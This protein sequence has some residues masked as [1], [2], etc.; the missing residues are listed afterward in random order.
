MLFSENIAVSTD[1]G[2]PRV[3]FRDKMGRKLTPKQG[4][5]KV[6]NRLYNYL[7][8][9]ELFIVRLAGFIPIYFLRWIIYRLA[10]VKIGSGSHIHM[11]AQFFFPAGV[12]IG[13]GSIIGQNAFLDGRESL[14]IGNYVDIASDVMIYNS[15]H[16]INSEDFSAH[17]EPVEIGDYTFIGPRA[18][19][20]PGVKI[21]RGAIVAAGAV[22]TKNVAEF[23]IVGGVPAK[24]VGERKVKELHYKLG[25]ARLFQ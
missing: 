7:L 8:D 1:D 10:G 23:K 15:E 17:S 13:R 19:I 11:G 21:G 2:L 24:E 20:L 14:I 9:F 18:V 16:D 4:I 22:V 5:G 12:E 3:E 25:R 6:F